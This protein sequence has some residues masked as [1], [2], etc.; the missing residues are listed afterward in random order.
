MAQSAVAITAGS[1]TNI[2][3]W[4]TATQ[5]Y[6]RQGIVIGDPSTDAAVAGVTNAAPGA[7][8]Y[9]VEVR[10]VGIPAAAALADGTTN[11]TL[12]AIQAHEMMYN[13]TTWDRIR[14]DTTNG[15]F[16][17]VKSSVAIAV[18]QSGTWNQRLQDGSGNAITST[19]AALDINIK[20]GKVAN[21]LSD[22]QGSATGIT[23]TLASLASVG[24]PPNVAG[25][26]STLV[27]NTSNLYVGAKVYLKI[28]L[29]TSPTAN[30]LI[31]VYLIQYDNSAVEDDGA[32]ASD[33]GL[34]V[35]NAPLLG[36][37]LNVSTSTGTVVYGIFDTTKI[38]DSLGPKWGIAVVNT[39]GASL[40]STEGN[41][42]KNYV[43]IKRQLN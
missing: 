23:I 7:S 40:D 5:Q 2:D 9:A 22:N 25:R 24:T 12:T 17:Q 43:G 34:T 31:Y 21:A 38:V 16:V 33:A 4:K 32:G 41:H 26:Q 15:L 37:I 11:P 8:D 28:K 3:A 20:S 19:G 14:G 27:D 13:G 6:Y 39:T 29:G 18:T 35:I 30:T 36:T 42:T 1:G 10:Q